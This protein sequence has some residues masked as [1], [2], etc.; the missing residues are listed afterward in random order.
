MNEWNEIIDL[1]MH[2]ETSTYF[3]I[4]QGKKNCF[5]GLQGLSAQPF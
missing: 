5:V 2:V 1:Q 3:P 4:I